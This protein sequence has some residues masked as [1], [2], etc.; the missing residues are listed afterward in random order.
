MKPPAARLAT[1]TARMGWVGGIGLSLLLA[2]CVGAASL[3]V[4]MRGEVRRLQDDIERMSRLPPRSTPRAGASQVA[5]DG[6]QAIPPSARDDGRLGRV[7]D[8]AAKHGL[9]LR[10][11]DYRALPPSAPAIGGVQLTLKTEGD[12]PRLRAF[13]SDLSAEVPGLAVTH[14]QLSRQKIGDS[15]L[16]TTIGA[17]LLHRRPQ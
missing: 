5:A 16:E 17:Q 3:Y 10:Q 8:I 6:L 14:L 12:Y 9:I 4:P 13:L 1:L 11:G 2:A 7:H 15:R